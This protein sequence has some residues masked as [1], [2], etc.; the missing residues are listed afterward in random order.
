VAAWQPVFESSRDIVGDDL[1]D[2]IYT[3]PDARKR[4]QVANACRDDV[5]TQVWVAE[6]EDE[7]TEFITFKMNNDR[8]VGEIGNNAVSPDFQGRGIGTQMY[9]F[10]LGK[11]KDAGMNGAIVETGSDDAYARARQ[12]YEKVG[13]SGAIPSL[14]Y[15]IEL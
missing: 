15:H 4:E 10:V 5:P 7:I 1:F 12:A 13:F 6:F 14:R 8:L 11:M 3:D 2:L 9:E